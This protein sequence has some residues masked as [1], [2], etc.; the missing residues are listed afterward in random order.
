MTCSGETVTSASALTG[1]AEVFVAMTV[2]GPAFHRQLAE[3]FFLDVHS[4]PTPLR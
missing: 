1:S 2:F 3:N 4:S